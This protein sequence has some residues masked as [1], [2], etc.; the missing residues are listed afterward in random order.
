MGISFAR[1]HTVQLCA[2]ANQLSDYSLASKDISFPL[3]R[4]IVAKILLENKVYKKR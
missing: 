2:T 1:V 3:Q 4:W